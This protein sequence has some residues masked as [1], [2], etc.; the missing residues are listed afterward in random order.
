MPNA[1]PVAQMGRLV[2]IVCVIGTAT[3]AA[4]KDHAPPSSP[5]SALL[6]RATLRVPA[7]SAAAPPGLRQMAPNAKAPES[8]DQAPARPA[9]VLVV[10]LARAEATL[11]QTA[12]QLQRLGRDER[13]KLRL[14]PM[15]DAGVGINLRLL[16]P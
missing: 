1:A 4:A 16:V 6:D 14:T 11:A 10:D 2:L 5:P 8:G 7:P 15:F 13:S 3:V 9:S 12:E